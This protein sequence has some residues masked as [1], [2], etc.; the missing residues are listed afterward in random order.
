ME[1]KLG[2]PPDQAFVLHDHVDQKGR[3]LGQRGTVRPGL[4][5]V[6][7]CTKARVRHSNAV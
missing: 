4:R 3:V 7:V 1:G 2:A 6:I 5:E